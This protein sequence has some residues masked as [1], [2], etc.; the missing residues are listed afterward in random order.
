MIQN[1]FVWNK[2]VNYLTSYFGI[3]YGVHRLEFEKYVLHYFRIWNKININ[4]YPSC[5][6]LVGRLKDLL[7]QRDHEFIFYRHFSSKLIY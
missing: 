7:W 5:S 2:N 4:L 3:V 6:G 1:I